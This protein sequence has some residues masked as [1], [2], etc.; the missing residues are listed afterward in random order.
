MSDENT[1]RADII[2]LQEKLKAL[3]ARLTESDAENTARY[4]T[5]QYVQTYVDT[6]L[7]DI[8]PIHDPFT[9]NSNIAGYEPLDVARTLKH[10]QNLGGS[11]T[12]ADYRYIL[13]AYDNAT[14]QAKINPYIAIAQMVKETDW[15][16][17]WWSQ[18][19]RRNP[20]G[21]GVTGEKSNKTQDR[22]SWALREDGIWLKGYSFPDWKIS[23]Q[24]HV[25]HLLT[26]LHTDDTLT[27]EQGMLVATD[28]R[29][30]FVPKEW[31]GKIKLLKDLDGKWAVPGQ[32][33]GRSIA[34]IANVLKQ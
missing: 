33:Y 26:Y 24:A 9:E 19:P 10:F 18:R 14:H 2:A 25:G 29:S 27:N 6:I 28:P 4:A 22:T 31:R 30:R 5:K 3:E 34:T 15:C 7:G 16:R 8:V 23:A 17:S 21:I 13:A 20:A 32:F 12:L 11:Y 1:M